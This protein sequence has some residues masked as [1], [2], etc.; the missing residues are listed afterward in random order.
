MAN[1]S[2]CSCYG[3]F[4][5]RQPHHNAPCPCPASQTTGSWRNSHTFRALLAFYSCERIITDISTFQLS[6]HAMVLGSPRSLVAF[7]Q[8]NN[9][10][11][12][13]LLFLSAFLLRWLYWSERLRSNGLF[14]TVRGWGGSTTWRDFNTFRKHHLPPRDVENI[15]SSF[16]TRQTSVY[17][18]RPGWHRSLSCIWL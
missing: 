2:F 3:M 10:C 5:S 15:R 14:A 12:S 7:V 17:V 8:A 1:R 9:E 11:T 6:F 13:M 4:C 16:A 18:K